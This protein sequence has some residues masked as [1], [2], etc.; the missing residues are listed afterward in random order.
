MDLSTTT[1]IPWICIQ[2]SN[3][4][5]ICLSW[6]CLQTSN[7]SRSCLQT[8]NISRI[9]LQTSKMSW[10]CLQTSKCSWMCLQT[11]KY[12]KLFKSL[13]H[14]LNNLL[15]CKQHKHILASNN[16]LK[17]TIQHIYTPTK[18]V[19]TTINILNNLLTL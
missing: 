9:C 17:S 4:L 1:R 19:N 3:I 13:I 11:N 16:I 5:W 18:I 15:N 7:I 2:T 10:I 6:I 14:L 8:S 12:I